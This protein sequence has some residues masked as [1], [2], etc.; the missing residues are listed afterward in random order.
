[1]IYLKGLLKGL[2]YKDE[3]YLAPIVESS[4]AL[5]YN[6]NLFREAGIPF[7]SEDPNNPMTWDEVL[8]IAKKINNPAKGVIGIRPG[9][10]IWCWRSPAYFKMPILWQ[11]GADVISPDGSTRKGIS[12]QK[13]H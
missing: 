13:K 2:T 9:P 4:I 1:M 8:E 3:I 11:F 6:I 12:I 10:G 5:F 7:P